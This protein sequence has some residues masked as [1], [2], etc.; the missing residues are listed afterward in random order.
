MRG[1]NA[2][3][4]AVFCAADAAPWARFSPGISSKSRWRGE[5]ADASSENV[6]RAWRITRILRPKEKMGVDAKDTNRAEHV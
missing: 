2:C 3:A 5:P 4:A 1:A 6:G